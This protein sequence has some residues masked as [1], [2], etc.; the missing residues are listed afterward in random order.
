M[1]TMKIALITGTGH[2][3]KAGT[4][5]VDGLGKAYLDF[6]ACRSDA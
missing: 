5:M 6:L 4:G 1:N 2:G 3:W